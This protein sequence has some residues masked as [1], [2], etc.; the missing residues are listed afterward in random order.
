ML[1][2]TYSPTT[3]ITIDETAFEIWAREEEPDVPDYFQDAEPGLRFA[4]VG[5]SA[6]EHDVI[7]GVPDDLSVLVNGDDDSEGTGFYV[8]LAPTSKRRISLTSGWTD[9][10]SLLR[11]LEHKPYPEAL[12]ECVETIVGELNAILQAIGG[13]TLKDQDNAPAS[14]AASDAE[15]PQEEISRLLAVANDGERTMLDELRRRAGIT[16]E[17]PGC[18]TN[19]ADE[20]QCGRCGRP[21]GE[22][23]AAGST[24]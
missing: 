23:E 5:L 19:M 20:T 1:K 22:V 3:R 10:G 21:R 15:L 12:R 13:L 6:L 8:L 9:L 14:S 11:G 16:W 24:R 17:H 4:V 18:W 2:I 7:A